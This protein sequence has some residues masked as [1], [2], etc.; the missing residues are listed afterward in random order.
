MPKQRPD[1]DLL[2]AAVEAREA[3]A[4]RGRLKIFFGASAGVGK[5]YAMLVAAQTIRRDAGDVVVGVLENAWPRR[6]R[7]TARRPRAIAAAH[8]RR[9][10][11]NGQ[12]IQ[13]RCGA[14]E[15]PCA[16]SRRRAR[17]HQCAGCAS[18]EAMAGHRRAAS[19]RNRCI[20]DAQCPAPRKPERRR[21]RHHRHPCVGDRSRHVF[22]R[23]RRR[24][25][26]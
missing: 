7:R 9:R 15:T 18:S 13:P 10:R 12:R 23:R 11:R 4:T 20:H 21:R 19:G 22:R 25:P 8:A 3:R 24:D 5:T 26:G 16:D 14:R 17:P 6:N 2:L 1:P